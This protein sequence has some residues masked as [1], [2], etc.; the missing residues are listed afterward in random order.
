M[1]HS[2]A[3]ILS[4]VAAAA[5]ADQGPLPIAD[6]PSLAF[7]AQPAPPPGLV[8]A[9]FGSLSLE[10]WP[11]TG[12]DLA[13][14]DADPINVLF[15]GNVDPL[16]LRA[17]LLSLNGN[18]TAWGFPATAPF[19]CTW[20]DAFGEVQSAYSTPGGWVANAIQLACGPY[21][22]L[23][24]H[25]RFFEAGAW[26]MAGAHFDLRIPGTADHQVISWELPEQLLLVDFLRSGLLDAVTPYG[27]API[28]PSPAYRTIEPIIFNGI[29]DPLKALVGLPTG[30]SSVPVPLPS[31]GRALVLH[32]ATRAPLDAGT[33]TDSFTIDFDQ[34][35]PRP[36][37]AS[38]P[39]DFVHAT[40]PLHFDGR[41]RTNGKGHLESWQTVRGK[42]NAIPLNPLT[43]Q[44]TGPAFEAIIQ[45]IHESVIT[46]NATNVNL[47][48]EQQ[49]LPP[50]AQNAQFL[51]LHL[52]TST[53]QAH[54][55]R[56]EQC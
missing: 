39:L 40:G 53:G 27:F 10:L 31:D 14:T 28:N 15:V 11:F 36:F 9:T 51:R 19:D 17:A 29:P 21:D 37:C 54:Y 23:R 34:F 16:S 18:R 30:S 4:A 12:R 41:V 49:A 3:L 35:I 44:P 6:P 8:T 50:G 46:P 32:V 42:L 2:V 5:C 38:G 52:R 1:Q 55:S 22:P 47:S 45:E 13:G 43:G 25:V 33:T 26:V 7:S 20:T 24:F 48:I 56:R